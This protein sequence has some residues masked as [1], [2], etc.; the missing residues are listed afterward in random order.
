MFRT[1]ALEEVEGAAELEVEVSIGGPIASEST[2]GR[3]GRAEGEE[4]GEGFDIAGAFPSLLVIVIV[5]AGAASID[6]DED[7]I[8]VVSGAVNRSCDVEPSCTS[9][10]FEVVVGGS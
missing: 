4:G 2:R 3:E 5:S 7:S 6:R 9:S 10:A 1:G 8:C